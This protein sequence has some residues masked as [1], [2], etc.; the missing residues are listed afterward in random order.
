MDKL[1]Y[2]QQYD[3]VIEAYFKNE[4]KPWDAQFCFCGNLCNKTDDWFEPFKG[5]NEPHNN[6]HGYSG[7]E[8]HNMERALLDT[9]KKRGFDCRSLTDCAEYEDALFSGLCAS[10]EVLRQIHI[11]RGEN[12]DEDIPAFTKRE[13]VKAL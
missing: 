2:R 1:T 13:L 5:D 7:W 6:S 9:L 10:L 8:L 4:I 11:D 3:K 12:V